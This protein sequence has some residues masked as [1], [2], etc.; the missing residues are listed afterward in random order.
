MT[1]RK[2]KERM[3]RA[4]AKLPT[5]VP[6]PWWPVTRLLRR[7]ADPQRR[8]VAAARWRA[9]ALGP[10][11]RARAARLRGAAPSGASPALVGIA[12]VDHMGDI[13]AAEPIA[14]ELRAENPR[15][16]IVWVV[17]E[18][19]RAL[20]EAYSAVDE[21]WT[22][23]CLTEWIHRRERHPFDR[24]VDLHVRGRTCDVCQVR[25][26][27]DDGH[28]SLDIGNYYH[29]GDLQQV[30]RLAAG[31]PPVTGA[32]RLVPPPAARRAVDE[33][34]LPATFVAFHARSAQPARDWRDEAW[35][36]LA[37][38]LLD[39]VGVDVV[40][41]GLEPVAAR[42]VEG[43]VDVCGRLSILET[44]EVIRR[45]RLFVGI[46]SGPAHLA[47]AV[48]SRAVLLMGTYR[49]YE[50][51]RPW[52]AAF[53]AEGR[54]EVLWSDGAAC[55]LEVDRVFEAVAGRLAGQPA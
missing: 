38:R 4:W 5:S 47:N 44:A 32:P 54:A 23:S 28:A 15:A 39:E 36:E 12:L 45:S 46:D 40:E 2:L 49:A 53:E 26:E 10:K 14:R 55:T 18:S 20:P 51:Y 25:L 13:V 48:G 7:I 9:Y 27:R 52:D 41:V 30:F 11:W 35:R 21:V 31:L 34:D 19:Y 42:D 43:C 17:R 29:H 3:D 33:L 24:L 16:R 22:V 50:R 6:P 8:H 37:R 1:L